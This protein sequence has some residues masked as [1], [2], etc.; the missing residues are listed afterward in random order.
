MPM[1]SRS[2]SGPKGPN[3]KRKE[4]LPG[5]IWKRATTSTTGK[6]SP[7]GAKNKAGEIRYFKTPSSAKRFASE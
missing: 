6:N 3:A 5:T 4:H 7:Y 1:K 2:K